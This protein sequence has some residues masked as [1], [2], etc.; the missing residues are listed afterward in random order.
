MI[1]IVIALTLLSFSFL[2]LGASLP[3][4]PNG[5]YDKSNFCS[6]ISV[7]RVNGSKVLDLEVFALIDRS[8]FPDIRSVIERFVDFHQWPQYVAGSENIK[9]T[10]SESLSIFEGKYTH[11]FDYKIK[12]PWPVRK[13]RVFG[14]TH[15]GEVTTEF[16]GSLLSYSFQ[17]DKGEDFGGVSK[18]YGNVHIYNETDEFYEVS[19]K[20]IVA[21][22]IKIG[23]DLAK[24]Y[25]RKPIEEILRGM[26]E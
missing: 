5:C 26:Y 12:A 15:F 6:T 7:K 25:V 4:K 24:P 11:K 19:Y 8:Q 9:F 20:S 17:I 13:S 18:Y 2:T 3:L 21:P 1:R 10:T 22:T 16:P 23:L 14:T